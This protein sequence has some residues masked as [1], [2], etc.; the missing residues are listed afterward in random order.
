M[1]ISRSILGM[2]LFLSVSVLANE[3]YSGPPE[4]I[5]DEV[6]AA[7]TL[8]SPFTRTLNLS[9]TL[10]LSGVANVDGYPVLL[11]LD[12]EVGRSVTVSER[13]NE[14]GWR[15][16]E[17]QKPGDLE[18][19]TASIAFGGGEIVRVRYDRERIEST[20]QRMR[21]KAK[22]RSQVA[23]ARSREQSHTGPGPAHGV[24]QERV[25][26]LRKI[27][28]TQLP[29]GYN[30]GAGKN[31]EEAHRLHQTFVDNRMAG[32]S[33]RQRGMVGHL[34]KQQQAVNPGMR[35]RGAS[36]VRIMEHVANHAPR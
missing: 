6:F 10:V 28:T 17:L 33:A 25:E 22:A 32:M 15:M 30:P 18:S 24:P 1:G 35:N 8:R 20:A 34:W 23:A 29:D 12:T 9:D 11:V 27:E 7:L 2:G 14:M 4:P 16:V 3:A 21:F 13:P 19:A 5:S 36:F 31:A 26:M